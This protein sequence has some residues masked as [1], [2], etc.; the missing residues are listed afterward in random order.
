MLLLIDYLNHSY[1]KLLKIRHTDLHCSYNNLNYYT[2]MNNDVR[3]QF[4]A[5]KINL[6]AFDSKSRL[7][8]KHFLVSTDPTNS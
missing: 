3:I 5:H 1:S 7:E 8:S 4:H 2:N 6:M